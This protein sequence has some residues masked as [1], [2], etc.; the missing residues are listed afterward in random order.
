MPIIPKDPLR[1][2]IKEYKLKDAKDIQE[3][4]KNLFGSTLKEILKAELTHEL[5]YSKHDY[6]NR[7]QP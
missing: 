4:L 7:K 1:A 2:L 5:G 3:M 6:K